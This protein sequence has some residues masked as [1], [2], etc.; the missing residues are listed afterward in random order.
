[1]LSR[2]MLLKALAKSTRRVQHLSLG[3]E[4][5]WLDTVW[6]S[7]RS[8]LLRPHPAGLGE[9]EGGQRVGLKMQDI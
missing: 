8:P 1:M 9:S 3:L 4:E 5:K 2:S 7:L 6:M